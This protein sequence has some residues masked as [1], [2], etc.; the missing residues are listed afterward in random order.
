M[1][2]KLGGERGSERMGS[3]M[4]R[5]RGVEALYHY[6]PASMV[7]TAHLPTTSAQNSVSNP[8][9]RKW[10]S[11]VNASVRPSRRITTNET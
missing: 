9:A 11:L 1:L 8:A 2:G 4:V 7:P 10:A 5:L 3:R 6:Y